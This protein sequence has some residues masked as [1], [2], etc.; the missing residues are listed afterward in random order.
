[1]DRRT[2]LKA[3]AIAGL[4]SSAPW[5]FRSARAQDGGQ[6]TFDGP[7]W[8]FVS[9]AGGWD[10]QFMFDPTEDPEYN[11]MYQGTGQVGNIPYAPI[12]ID[13]ERLDWDPAAGIEAHVLTPEQ[14]LN[15]HGGRLTVINGVDTTTNN[16]DGG[17]RAMASGKLG[18]GYPA[19]AALIAAKEAPSMPMSFFSGGGYDV[20]GGHIPLTRV[21]N[22]GSFN[23]I[24]R[25][26]EISAGEP[27]TALYHTQETWERIARFQRERNEALRERQRLPALRTAMRELLE[28]RVSTRVLDQLQMPDELIDLAPG[29][30]NALEGFMR[31]G[32]MVLAAFRSGLSAT[33]S[34][35]YG[36][37]DTH[38]NHDRDQTRKVLELLGGLDFLVAEADRLGLGDQVNIVVTSDFGR[39]PHYNG[40]NDNAG[41]DHW[42]IT[43]VLAMGP[44]FEGDRLVGATDDRQLARNVDPDTLEVV[45]EGGVKIG[46]EHVHHALRELA[47]LDDH[48]L[49]AGYP[50]PGEPLPLFG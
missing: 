40:E 34:I 39:G 41:K 24:A 25:P 50:L 11:R 17:A 23:R 18:L 48:E 27:D 1:M 22:A 35:N 12:G 4:A 47:G 49:T 2:F 37:W 30:L 5:V 32:Q 8:I 15:A 31:Q 28:A 43:S 7:Y 19:L 20:T 26:N 46:P 21:S 44:A 33:G 10:P 38:G 6:G 3:S 42:P 16:H 45:S 36:G 9:A 13:Y 14:F 29:E